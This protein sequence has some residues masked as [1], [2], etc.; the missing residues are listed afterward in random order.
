MKRRVA[1]SLLDGD[2]MISQRQ[3]THPYI[4]KDDERT[5]RCGEIGV[6]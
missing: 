3:D 2:A 6:N 1:G 4:L 5:L